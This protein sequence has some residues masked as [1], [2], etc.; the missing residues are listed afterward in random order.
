MAK[1]FHFSLKTLLV[2]MGVAALLCCG[3]A[4]LYHEFRQ[5]WGYGPYSSF[6]E[7]P[8]SLVDL[9]DSDAALVDD[10]E[11][12]GLGSFVDHASIWRIK[13]G[14]PLR[15]RLFAGHQLVAT[16][17]N[18]PMVPDLLKAAPGKWISGDRADYNWYATPGYGSQHIEGVDLFLVAEYPET[19]EM[20]VLHEWLF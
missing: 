11:P 17:S 9:I 10:V 16:T 18:H 12:L 4:M 5:S 14:S 3:A 20:I 13:P 1:R 8:R 2:L 15:Q 19:G 7:W 6:D